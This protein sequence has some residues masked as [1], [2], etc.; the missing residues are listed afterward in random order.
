VLL[1]HNEEL[2]KQV[3]RTRTEFQI[4]SDLLT[5]LQEHTSNI[6][7]KQTRVAHKI[8]QLRKH[9]DVGVKDLKLQKS[10]ILEKQ[11]ELHELITRLKTLLTEEKDLRDQVLQLTEGL[12]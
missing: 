5:E 10:Q 12:A 2:Q 4:K 9:K 1:S 8:F 3:A 7:E 11:K 6:R